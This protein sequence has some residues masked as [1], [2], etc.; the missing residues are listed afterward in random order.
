MPLLWQKGPNERKIKPNTTTTTK[1]GSPE[2]ARSEAPGGA[3][4][5]DQA[6]CGR[7]FVPLTDGRFPFVAGL[8]GRM[9][10]R[11]PVC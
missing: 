4:L 6:R 1:P 7:P 3:P 2:I 11:G 10:Q 9:P 5:P 8:P